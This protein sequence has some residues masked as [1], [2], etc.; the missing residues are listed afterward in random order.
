MKKAM[1]IVAVLV[2]FGAGTINLVLLLYYSTLTINNIDALWNLPFMLTWLTAPLS[3]LALLSFSYLVEPRKKSFVIASGLSF[4]IA[5]ALEILTK[6]YIFL[7][8]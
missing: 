6:N 5:V 8:Q 4:L 7:R 1:K 2:V 3:L